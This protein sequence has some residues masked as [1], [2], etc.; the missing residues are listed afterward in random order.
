[1][2]AVTGPALL[3]CPAD[4]PDRYAKALAVADTVIIDLEDA[5]AAGRKA[6]ARQALLDTAV[7]PARTLVR[8]N[9]AG[10]AEHALDLAALARTDYR[11]VMLAKTESVTDLQGLA[12]FAVVALCE[13]ARGVLAAP[14]I[15]GA[16]A[17]V[18]VM[19]GAEDLMASIGG[20]SSRLPDGRYRAVASHAR[21]RVLL[22]AGAAGKDAIDS[23]YLD[24]DDQAGL[25][26]ESADAVASGFAAKACV[27]PAQAAVVRA[28]F[29]PSDEQVAWARRVVAAV[30]AGGVTT[31]D[32][33][34][35]D[36]PLL[37]QAER[38][39]SRLT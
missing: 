36:A 19:W 37:R 22:A 14:E 30:S 2:P 10:T 26:E 6:F 38:V 33:Q 12:G 18:A 25:A 32:R 11:S 5:V 17:V 15:A 7:D 21:S 3:F 39:L 9:P 23:V 8:I 29:A 31:V 34:M 16:A 20:Q 28:A 13:T 27:H 1:M 24:L 4:R 35:V